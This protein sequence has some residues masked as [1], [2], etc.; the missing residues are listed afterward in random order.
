MAAGAGAEP[1]TRDGARDAAR[2]E[3]SKGI[4]HHDDE[5]WPLRV[6]NAI[7]RWLEHLLRSAS[8]HAPGGGAGA[9]ALLLIALLLLAFVWWRVGLV[10]RTAHAGQP[11]LEDRRRTSADLLREAE[12]AV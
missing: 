10:Q 9:I 3:L 7:Q 5:P 8:R 12:D 6:F 2:H 1:I 4:Y 11:L